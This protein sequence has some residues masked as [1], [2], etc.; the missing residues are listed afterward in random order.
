[1]KRGEYRVGIV[2]FALIAFA[3]GESRLFARQAAWPTRAQPPS[4]LRRARRK[5][6]GCKQSGPGFRIPARRK[7]PDKRHDY[8]PD[9]LYT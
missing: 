1:M 6:P 3:V 5:A 4:L 8:V 9:F 7:G 2:V